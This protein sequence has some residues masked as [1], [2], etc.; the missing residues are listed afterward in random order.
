MS[1]LIFKVC[2]ERLIGL[3]ALVQRINELVNAHNPVH[4]VEHCG[5]A[6]SDEPHNHSHSPA[7]HNF[8]RNHGLRRQ[9]LK[10]VGDATAVIR[11][12]V[13]QLLCSDNVG[14]K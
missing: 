7:F 4:Q 12:P 6:Y 14:L 9:L 10:P 11:C 1:R 2:R 3:P 13:P 8:R 5:S